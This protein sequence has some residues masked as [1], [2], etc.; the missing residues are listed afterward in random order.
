MPFNPREIC[1]LTV[2]GRIY[3]DWKSV[4]VYLTS[5]EAFN[6]YRFTASERVTVGAPPKVMSEVQ[7]RPG[8]ICTVTLGGEFAIGGYVTTRQVAYT[9]KAHGVEITGKGYTSATVNGGASVKG[10]EIVN[11]PF[12][13]LAKKLLTPYGL[14]LQVKDGINMQPFERFNCTGQ[15]CWEAMESAAR[16]R[17]IVLTPNPKDGKSFW[18]HTPSYS[19]G[20]ARLEEGVNILEGRETWSMEFGTGT[21]L[22]LAQQAPTPQLWGPKVT[23]EPLGQFASAFASRLGVAGQFM[24]LVSMAEQPGKQEGAGQ[25]SETE[26]TAVSGEQIKVE[27]VVQGWFAPNGKLWQPRN[28]V[29]VK[30]PS[31]IMDRSLFLKSATFTQDDRSGTRTTLELVNENAPRGPTGL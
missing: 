21:Y 27:I 28:S 9:E 15:H 30:S 25:R 29:Y 22:T 17:N 4:T 16:Q 14:Q 5:S 7:V 18:A 24:P 12:P 19:E 1:Q 2:D 26:N 13:E 6:Y 31:L 3:E 23:S 8:Q 20:E 10:G 11:S